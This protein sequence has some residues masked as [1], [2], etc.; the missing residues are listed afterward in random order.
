MEE[1]KIYRR[2]IL[3]LV[4]WMCKRRICVRIIGI[5]A[6]RICRCCNF[7]LLPWR[8]HCMCKLASVY[9]KWTHHMMGLTCSHMYSQCLSRC[10]STHYDAV[11][12]VMIM[13]LLFSHKHSWNPWLLAGIKGNIVH[14]QLYWT[15]VFQ[16]LFYDNIFKWCLMTWRNFYLVTRV[17]NVNPNTFVIPS[18]SKCYLKATVSKICLKR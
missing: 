8:P 11:I 14:Q 15:L 5:T 7:L 12:T 6:T 9:E 2:C 16:Y 1:Q 3:A 13:K 18:S 17:T 4:S 10:F